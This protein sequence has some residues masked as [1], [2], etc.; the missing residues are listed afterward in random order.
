MKIFVKSCINNLYFHT[1]TV[2]FL[3]VALLVSLVKL[4]LQH[5]KSNLLHDS[6]TSWL[7]FSLERL[8]DNHFTPIFHVLLVRHTFVF[9]CLFMLK[10]FCF[11]LSKGFCS[12]NTCGFCVYIV[13]FWV[14][15][16]RTLSILW[17][18]VSNNFE[19]WNF[20][21]YE[22]DSKRNFIQW[23]THSEIK[24]D[25]RFITFE[26]SRKIQKFCHKP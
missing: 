16:S 5:I 25:R 15:K 21:K 22:I 23:L 8:L 24:N 20:D 17:T 3:K 26:I 12:I 14:N 6:R 10:K 1:F 18:Q 7:W 19:K 11:V 9:L 13:L 2:N 4:I